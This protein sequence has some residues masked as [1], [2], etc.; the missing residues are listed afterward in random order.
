MS[1]P[2]IPTFH[3]VAKPEA[4][5]TA[6]N[7]RFTVLT[8][9]LIRMEYSQDG[10]FEDRPSQAFWH[11]QQP[12]PKFKKI[13][14]DSSV[15]IETDFLHLKYQITP[16]GFTSKTL[17]IQLKQT[18]VT[19]RYGESQK[20][21]LKGTART[22]DG[23]AGTT[24]LENGLL[25]RSGWSVVDD[26]QSLVFNGRGWLEPRQAQT[27]RIFETLRVSSKDLYFFGYGSDYADP[28]P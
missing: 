12:V 21:N 19:W 15:E 22:L 1:F 9:R 5:V 10:H 20:D 18:G 3:P 11:R 25:S 23:V 8:D 24:P 26:S 4:V 28:F 6:K 16:R 13:V 14:T 2:I 27:L 17:S 7:V